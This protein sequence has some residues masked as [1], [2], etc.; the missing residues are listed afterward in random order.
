MTTD[1]LVPPDKQKLTP[2]RYTK[3]PPT[4]SRPDLIKPIDGLILHFTA[5]G[6][7]SSTI[8]HLCEPSSQASAH[9]VVDRDGTIWQLA[10][11][12]DR[13]WH[14][15]GAT[16]SFLGQ[17]NTNG[18]TIGIEM[19]NWGVLEWD[20]NTNQFLTWPNADL[21][22]KKQP[23]Q[24]Y[25][26]QI[27]RDPKTPNTKAWE[28]YLQAQ[29]DSVHYLIKELADLFPII[30]SDPATRLVGHED[31]DPMRK[32]DP[33]KAWDWSATRAIIT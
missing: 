1:W 3:S 23:Y 21:R 19:M 9:F 18:R 13:T 15:G 32:V 16:S 31:V 5:S 33:G 27:F 20:S 17:R 11:L 7:I 10:P 4:P 12:S 28:P 26:G 8:A 14:A 30:K 25:R 2:N 29:V 22:K 24:F 6:N